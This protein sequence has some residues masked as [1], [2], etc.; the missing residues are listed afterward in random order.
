[1]EISPET[2]SQAGVVGGDLVKVVSPAGELRAT[3]CEVPGMAPGVVAMPLL[4]KRVA[5]EW[6]ADGA[7]PLDL[8]GKG[9]NESGELALD[10]GRVRLVPTGR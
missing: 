3:L 1:M 8:L 7:N 5:S 10:S 6:S 2:A 9:Q 4:E